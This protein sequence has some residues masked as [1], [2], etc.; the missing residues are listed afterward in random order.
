MNPESAILIDRN[1]KTT[2]NKPKPN[3]KPAQM[4]LQQIWQT[5]KTGQIQVTTVLFSH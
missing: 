3:I 1:R 5:P 4:A 2:G